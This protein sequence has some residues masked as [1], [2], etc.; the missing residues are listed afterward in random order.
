VDLRECNL[1]EELHTFFVFVFGDRFE[2]KAMYL[3][4]RHSTT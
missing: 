1:P 2:L 3:V 4:G